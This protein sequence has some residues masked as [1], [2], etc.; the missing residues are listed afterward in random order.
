MLTS[1]L[2]PGVM[3]GIRALAQYMNENKVVCLGLVSDIRPRWA[4]RGSFVPSKT[5]H[6]FAI[7]NRLIEFQIVQKTGTDIKE[8]SK[9]VSKE[10]KRK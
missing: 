8:I 1:K 7:Y 10:R 2:I 6:I 9:G 4:L 3:R 5:K